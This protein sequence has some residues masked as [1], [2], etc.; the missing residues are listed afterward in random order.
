M[1][2]SSGVKRDVAN[3]VSSVS[4]TKGSKQNMGLYKPLP[5]PF[6]PWKHLS[7]DFILGL[8]AHMEARF[9]LHCGV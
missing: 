6:A 4:I 3:V 9:N 5:I 7:M 2:S 1:S 8:L